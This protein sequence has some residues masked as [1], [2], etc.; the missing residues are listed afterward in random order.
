MESF[1][2]LRKQSLYV[3]FWVIENR[4]WYPWKW[5]IAVDQNCSVSNDP[6]SCSLLNENIIFLEVVVQ[7]PLFSL[8][9]LSYIPGEGPGSWLLIFPMLSYMAFLENSRRMIW[10]VGCG[11]V[12]LFNVSVRVGCVVYRVCFIVS[13]GCLVFFWWIFTC[14]I[15]TSSSLQS[16]SVARLVWWGGRLDAH[17][18]WMRMRG[19]SA[20]LMRSANHVTA[21]RGLSLVNYPMS[22][23]TASSSHRVVL[24]PAVY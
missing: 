22:G 7:Q 5:R 8:L 20:Y 15:Y 23:L 16:D 21:P 1:E 2:F 10:R 17:A 9:L 18:W 3:T 6:H 13:V 11:G 19:F 14:F 12:V 4:K 24:F